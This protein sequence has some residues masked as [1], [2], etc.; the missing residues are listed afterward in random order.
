MADHQ[1][2]SAFRV[3]DADPEV[4]ER[5]VAVLDVQAAN[6]GVR[7]LREWAHEQLAVRPGERVLDIGSGT[8][9][10]TLVLAAAVGPDGAATGLEP[11]PGLR[12][13]AGRRAAEAGSAAR[14][15]DGDALAL[16]L[17]D[18]AVDAVRCERVLQHLS[19]PAGAVAEMARVLRPG[20]RV[21]L[22][23]TDWSTLLLHPAAAE[24]RT[25]L[26]GVT[27][28]NSATPEAGRRLTG[29]LVAAGL[30]VDHVGADV[31]LHDPDT[32]PWPLLR[33]LATVAVGRGLLTEAQCDDLYA[34]LTAAAE[35]RAFHLSV[36]MFAAVA[37]RPDGP[38]PSTG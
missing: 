22:L 36:T 4:V 16:P 2:F 17:P 24:A 23:D 7:R 25:A 38:A 11:N 18:G 10:E 14:F 19:D 8:G 29:W 26:T 35:R 28:G 37:H 9:S 32:V 1:P 6:P 20:G 21:A 15:L 33:G 30:T 5:L 31:L 12:A 27:L 13:V 3:P 34:E